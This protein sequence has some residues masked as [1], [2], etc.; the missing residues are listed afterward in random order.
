[1]VTVSTTITT[2]GH[3]IL[4]SPTQDLVNDFTQCWDDCCCPYL[5][6]MYPQHV[7]EDC[8]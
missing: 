2:F 3:C 6:L 4:F 1:M 8:R 7:V 5:P